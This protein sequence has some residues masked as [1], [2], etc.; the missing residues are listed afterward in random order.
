M[1]SSL[2]SVCVCAKVT[3]RVHAAGDGATVVTGTVTASSTLAVFSGDGDDDD[4]QQQLTKMHFSHRFI[5][6]STWYTGQCVF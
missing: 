3:H 1:L 2:F 6:S 4:Y 5:F